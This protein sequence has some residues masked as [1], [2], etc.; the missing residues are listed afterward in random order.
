MGRL[1]PTLA[2]LAAAAFV[3]P[4]AGAQE[5]P[6]RPVKWVSP[7]P[8]G[9]ANDIFSR[10]ISQKLRSPRSTGR[11]RKPP[12]AAEAIGT[13]FVARQPGDGTP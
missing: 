9:G 13:E 10:A 6:A 11:A 5:W 12:G 8:P 4:L 3:T 1:F 2:L 7:W